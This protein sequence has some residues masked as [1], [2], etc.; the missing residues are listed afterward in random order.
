MKQHFH[1]KIKSEVKPIMPKNQPFQCPAEKCDFEVNSGDSKHESISKRQVLM[2]YLRRHGILKKY[3]NDALQV[4]G[5][6]ETQIEISNGFVSCLPNTSVCVLCGEKTTKED[7]DQAMFNHYCQ[8]HFRN[9]IKSEVKPL[10]MP[11][12]NRNSSCPDKECDFM[13]DP[14]TNQEYILLKHYLSEHGILKKFIEEE[15]NKDEVN[16]V[17]KFLNPPLGKKKTRGRKSVCPLPSTA[18]C[19]LCDFENKAPTN[20]N[21]AMISHYLDRH[22]KDKITNEIKPILPNKKPFKCPGLECDFVSKTK[23][24]AGGRVQILLH[25]TK[26]H[27]I[28]NRLIKEASKE[29][30]KK[31]K[32][33]NT[34][35]H[36]EEDKN[37]KENNAS[38]RIKRYCVNCNKQKKNQENFKFCID[39]LNREVLTERQ[40]HICR[41][42][43]KEFSTLDEAYQHID[44][45]HCQ[46][47]DTLTKDEGEIKF[48]KLGRS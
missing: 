19:K 25:Y 20:R 42:C 13:C 29:D 47:Y 26:N 30:D 4:K 46:H 33:K 16:D 6:Q 9:R 36:I 35:K 48:F 41:L 28:I 39:C 10:M 1:E 8:K 17:T 27:G 14:K 22:F 5:Q 18:K 31:Q 45:E 11:E 37:Q 32:D 44:S 3:I 15:Q 7:K 2:H 12:K 43:D 24:N 40:Q 21:T 23:N 34:S 38:K